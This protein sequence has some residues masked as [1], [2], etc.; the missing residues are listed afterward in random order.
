MNK[1]ATVWYHAKIKKKIDYYGGYPHIRSFDMSLFLLYVACSARPF[2]S[3]PFPKEPIQIAEEESIESSTSALETEE[4]DSD[5]IEEIIESSTQ[6]PEREEP[7]IQNESLDIQL[8]TDISCVSPCSFSID[9]DANIVRV[10]YKADQWEIGES[11]NPQD[12]F[13]IVYEFHEEGERN[14]QAFAYDITGQ[15]VD[16]DKR[17]VDVEIE[18]QLPESLISL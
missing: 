8:I 17:I 10:V 13:S 6:E 5:D 12:D 3:D 9:S 18:S 16:S 1:F 2:S 4:D 14:I 7:N 11:E 15:L